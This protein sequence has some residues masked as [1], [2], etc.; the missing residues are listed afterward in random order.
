[1]TIT[2]IK[3]KH[4]KYW[5]IKRIIINNNKNI[6]KVK[7]KTWTFLTMQILDKSR[8]RR[9]SFSS[10]SRYFPLLKTNISESSFA[11]NVLCLFNLF[12]KPYSPEA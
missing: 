7:K 9:G 8:A 1:M 5:T 6:Q 2:R 4:S 3:E 10:I 12:I 11:L